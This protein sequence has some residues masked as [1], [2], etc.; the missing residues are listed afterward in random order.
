MTPY[1]SWD[2]CKENC[3]AYQDWPSNEVRIYMVCGGC[4]AYKMHQYLKEHGQI[5]EEEE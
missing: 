5:I 1:K 3:V 2:Y 4:H